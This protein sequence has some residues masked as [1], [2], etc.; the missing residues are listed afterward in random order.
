MLS[1]E[2]DGLSGGTTGNRTMAYE[3]N[4][5]DGTVRKPS[6]EVSSQRD[7]DRSLKS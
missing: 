5:I 7:V 4:W 1:T 3:L 2:R 6:M